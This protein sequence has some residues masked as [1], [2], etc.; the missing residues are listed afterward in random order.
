MIKRK[1]KK[2]EIWGVGIMK[3]KMELNKLRRK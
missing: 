1:I 2:M 3:E